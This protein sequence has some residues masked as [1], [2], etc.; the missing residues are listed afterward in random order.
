MSQ[1]ITAAEYR[2][3]MGLREPRPIGPLPVGRSSTRREA[4]DMNK[5]EA[6]FIREILEPARIRGEVEAWE[7]EGIKLRLAG[8]TWYTPDF[9][10]VRPG[11]V[12]EL[13]EV[14]GFWR[15]D[16]RVKIK[17]AAERWAAFQFFGA[18]K[19]KRGWEFEKF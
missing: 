13:Y 4:G 15:D 9:F 14:K 16:A 17:V 8:R 6:A 19:G 5:L 2:R 12:Y 7:F 11:L 10:V 1:E 3:R 18:R